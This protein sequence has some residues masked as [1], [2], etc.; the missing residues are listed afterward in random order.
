MST[1]HS[2]GVL[3]IRPALA[4]GLLALGLCGVAAR[5]VA[6]QSP[7]AR[8]L[9]PELAPLVVEHSEETPEPLVEREHA[10]RPPEEIVLTAL[11][12]AEPPLPD[13]LDRHGEVLATS[14][15]G[16]TVEASP[17]HLW[18]VHTPDAILAGLADVLAEHAP[19]DLEQRLLGTDE[20][21]WRSVETWQLEPAEARALAAW[22]EAGGP[23]RYPDMGPLPG[24]VLEACRPVEGEG[25]VFFRLRWNP[26]LLLSAETRRR[27][28]R[29]LF[30]DKQ[31]SASSWVRSLSEHLWDLLAGPRERALLARS[32]AGESVPEG[33]E[34]VPPPSELARLLADRLPAKPSWRVSTSVPQWQ[35][36]TSQREWVFEGLVH[37]RYEKICQSLPI[38]SVEAVRAFL[39]REHVSGFQIWL[40]PTSERA[41]PQSRYALLGRVGWRT[42]D[43][44]RRHGRW[45]LEHAAEAVLL[46]LGLDRTG[47][48]DS[49]ARKVL[50]RAR[51]DDQEY[52]GS[53]RLGE[54]VPR[55]V[56]TIDARLQERL[57]LA[58]ERIEEENSTS[59]T[60]GIVVDLET[61]DVLA[62]DWRDPYELGI[63][64]PVQHGFTP[65]STFKVVTMALALDAGVVSPDERFDVGT[66]AFLV[67]GTRRVVGEAEGFAKGVITA[68]ECL[69]R[70]SNAGMIQIGLMLSPKTWIERT[71]ALGY[72]LPSGGDLISEGMSGFKGTIGE[73]SRG[74]TDNIWARAR[75]HTSVCFGDSMSI[76]MLQHVTA[77]AAIV[78]DGQVRPLRFV[79]AVEDG[80]SR[81]E[82]PPS[83]GPRV[84]KP[85]TSV[86]VHQMMQLGATEGTGKRIPRPKDLVLATKTGTYEKLAGD[87]SYHVLGRALAEARASGEAWN[88]G[89]AYRRYRGNW[90]GRRSAY[91]S[92][93]VAVGNVEG[94][95][96]RVL[97]FMLAED[98]LGEEHFGS[99]V[100][101]DAAVEVLCS[102]LGYDDREARTLAVH[103]DGR[104]RLAGVPVPTADEL[105][106]RPWEGV[107]RP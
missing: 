57:S 22:I 97:V 48:I 42:D 23:T 40:R 52:Y 38:E 89:E 92:S 82:L 21:G 35:I 98:P 103:D 49:F 54:A 44:T 96:R 27:M 83:E 6:A 86:K 32:T 73:I 16:H 94:S 66:G 99:Y 76:N 91:T 68:S 8:S 90:D 70:S 18:L 63:Y 105:P 37:S 55:V 30:D 81:V 14:V 69:A 41:Y 19:R 4:F 25:E 87:V 2:T 75:S 9:P 12:Y 45:G 56:T 46:R 58:L 100:T 102:A 53:H 39:A 13:L 79:D 60:M 74:P 24:L 95:S 36:A 7:N 31:V 64:A 78:S 26:R 101:G 107:G 43:L 34:L 104:P 61:R 62:L 59:L 88:G 1:L 67:P 29:D 72:G 84:L 65:G 5:I 80:T 85:A 15:R 77:I 106:E 33:Y 17:Y 51:A 11:D 50:V 20:Y 47:A 71:A 93:I 10:E 3:R 28:D